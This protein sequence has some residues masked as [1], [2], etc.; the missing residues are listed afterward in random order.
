M[1]NN[2]K[3]KASAIEPA[4]TD[5]LPLAKRGRPA[6]AKPEEETSS[7]APAAMPAKRGRPKTSQQD[8]AAVSPPNEIVEAP[9]TPT[10]QKKVKPNVSATRT[11]KRLSNGAA[12]ASNASLKPRTRRPSAKGVENGTSNGTVVAVKEAKSKGKGK[13]KAV[14]NR[15]VDTTIE[16]IPVSSISKVAKSPKARKGPKGTKATPV[17]N[18]RGSR[19]SNISVAVPVLGDETLE[20]DN[21]D[22]EAEDD[23]PG[24]YLCKAEPESRI[25]KGKDVKFSIDDLRAAAEPEGWDGRF[26]QSCS[27]FDEMLMSI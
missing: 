25:E 5:T 17:D 18:K 6:K 20:D 8:E 11:S 22:D 26:L 10:R 12:D 14:A 2:K 23:G 1:A 4:T 21:A 7:P 9:A 3:R 19:S 13:A 27:Y 24:Y 16:T 15:S